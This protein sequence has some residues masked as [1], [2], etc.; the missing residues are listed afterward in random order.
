MAADELG[1]AEDKFLNGLRTP[2]QL[3]ALEKA[4]RCRRMAF[5]IPKSI[6]EPP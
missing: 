4:E 6:P 2:E 1:I 3:A 5:S